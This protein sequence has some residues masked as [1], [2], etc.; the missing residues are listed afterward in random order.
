MALAEAVGIDHRGAALAL[1]DIAAEP[2]RLTE[3]EPGL[4]GVAALDHR[5]PEDQHVDPRIAPAGGG[6][7]RQADR[8]PGARC[9]PGLDSGQATGFQL[10]DDL[11]GDFGIEARPVLTGASASG[12][13]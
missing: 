10:G 9:A 5:A 11:V 6:V 1:A 7:P 4:A 12:R 2:E 13:A 3:G 8:R